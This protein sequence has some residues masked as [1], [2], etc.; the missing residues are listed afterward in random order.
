[1][2][3]CSKVLAS[4]IDAPIDIIKIIK[5]YSHEFSLEDFENL[6]PTD[7]YDYFPLSDN[8]IERLGIPMPPEFK[9]FKMYM[10]YD[11]SRRNITIMIS[12][13]KDPDFKYPFNHIIQIPFTYPVGIS[14]CTEPMV[15]RGDP[16]MWMQNNGGLKQFFEKYNELC[17]DLL[18]KINLRDIKCPY[19]ITLADDE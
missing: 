14:L 5:D 16:P 13:H 3:M 19:M 1:M 8:L 17:L 10:L 18:Y 12:K 6:I 11:G 9:C 15:L 4:I 7:I 2:A